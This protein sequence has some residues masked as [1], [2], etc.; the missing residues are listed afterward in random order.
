[1]PAILPRLG[2]TRAASAGETRSIAAADV[3]ASDGAGTRS[4]LEFSAWRAPTTARPMRSP[5]CARAAPRCNAARA[6]PSPARSAASIS[7]SVRRSRCAWLP[8]KRCAVSRTGSI[9]AIASAYR[10]RANARAL[11]ERKP[12]LAR[13]ICRVGVVP[14]RLRHARGKLASSRLAAGH[15]ERHRRVHVVE[16]VEARLVRRARAS[17]SSAT[18]SKRSPTSTPSRCSRH[19]SAVASTSDRT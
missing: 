12:D 17:Q 1:M 8:P 6:S 19:R 7:V 10:P 15:R 9:A 3:R 18:R 14:A 4:G 13:V 16:R 11:R 2:T 5:A